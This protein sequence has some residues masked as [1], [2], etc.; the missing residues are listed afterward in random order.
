MR[1][2][3]KPI[4]GTRFLV[5]A[6]LSLVTAIAVGLLVSARPAVGAFPGANGKIA[7]TSGRDGTSEIYVMN[8]DGSG[9]TRLTN[10]PGAAAPAWSPDGE[11]IA[12]MSSDGVNPSSTEIYVM[13]ADGA[14]QTRLTNN[15]VGDDAPAWSP[16][17]TKIAFHRGCGT[18]CVEIWVMDADG[19]NQAVLVADTA[20]DVPYYFRPA[21]SPDGTEIALSRSQSNTNIEICIVS[22]ADGSFLRCTANGVN[23]RLAD[24]SP[25]GT[26]LA[27]DRG[28]AGSANVYVMNRDLSGQMQLTTDGVSESA[29][30]SPEGTKIVFEKFAPSQFDIWVMNANGSGQTN[31]TPGTLG[32]G[33]ATGYDYAPSWQPD[34]DPPTI[35][36]DSPADGGTY[37]LN[38]VVASSYTCDDPATGVVTCAGPVA[39]GADFSTSPVGPH[40][41]TVNAGDAAGNTAQATSNYTV[42]YDFAGFF[43]PV[44]NTP[45]F[46]MVKAGSA[47]PV[48]FSLGGDQGLGIFATGYPKSQ[49]IPCDA[50]ATYDGIEE[51]VTAGSSSLSYDATTDRY[52][53]VWKTDKAWANTCR[54]L[55]VKLIDGTIHQANF[56]FKK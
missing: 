1:K 12:F 55:V 35:D 4:F 15:T 56:T 16:D 44:D 39:S 20:P 34:P 18:R 42:V 26:K 36:I 38:A 51:T 32:T 28:P 45:V 2:R 11:K 22:A 17:G 8:A 25:D 53:Y 21:W 46:N 19:M 52:H 43:P 47:I 3:L 30:W 50:S 5:A 40:A 14:D 23:S 41:F 9:Q 54:Q 49:P 13:D 27:F 31:L 10:T 24:W 29:A 37:L 33:G 6:L 7:F 48:K